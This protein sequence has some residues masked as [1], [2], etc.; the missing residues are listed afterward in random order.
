MQTQRP[1]WQ[2]LLLL[3]PLSLLLTIS[4]NE[5]R[6][7]EPLND[8]IRS[9]V[10]GYTSGVI[11]KA[12]NIQVKFA[13]AAV[14]K[15]EIGPQLKSSPIS[16]SPSIQGKAFWADE[17]T[18]VFQPDEY[19]PSKTAYI[20][21]VELDEI[22]KHVPQEARSFEFD[23]ETREQ[24]LEVELEVLQAATPDQLVKQELIGWVRTSDV[25]EG[26]GVEK[27]LTADQNGK[28]LPIKWE[29]QGDELNHKF[30]VGE[31][32]AGRQGWANVLNWNGKALDVDYKGEKV[33]EVPSV[34]NFKVVESGLPKP[35]TIY[36]RQFLRPAPLATQN[37]AG[38]IGISEYDGELK[39][40]VAPATAC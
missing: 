6:S 30:T 10:Y 34:S 24:Y 32:I 16:F 2:R 4:C 8:L 21:T 27:V 40:A 12:S 26:E 23:F 38:I 7:A 25:A 37:L 15:D 14:R 28:S 19:L 33:V 35:T 5:K 22:F 20:A 29:H 1:H 13:Q 17:S 31:I 3:L 18:L 11:S 36:S 39:S 9:Y